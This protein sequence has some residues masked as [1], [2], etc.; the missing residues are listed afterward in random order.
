MPSVGG[1]TGG[2]AQNCKVATNGKD[3]K[4]A[5]R[6]HETHE[7]TRKKEKEEDCWLLSFFRVF[8]CVSWSNSEPT[9]SRAPCSNAAVLPPTRGPA[10]RGWLRTASRGRSRWPGRAGTVPD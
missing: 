9:R 1:T 7:K 8:S 2:L 5:K 10:F 3:G 4:G 6:V